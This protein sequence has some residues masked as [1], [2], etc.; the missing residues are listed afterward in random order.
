MDPT[1]I[2]LPEDTL[3]D[4][5]S[6]YADYG[7]SARS[8]YIRDIIEHRDPPF[9]TT[10]TTS[11]YAQ[12]TTDDYERLRDRVDEL[13]ERLDE[14]V[15]NLN[16]QNGGS[17]V[18]SLVKTDS[19]DFEVPEPP[20]SDLEPWAE[21]KQTALELLRRADQPLRRSEILERV[22]EYDIQDRSIW[23]RHLTPWLKDQG[24]EKDGKGWVLDE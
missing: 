7:Y 24:V 13:E 22:P 21:Q 14:M 4:L 12:P 15:D 6:E 8:D 2:R 20:S 23:E 1:T 5:D 10:E 16:Q 3:A 17:D 9:E 18:A 19:L 11:D